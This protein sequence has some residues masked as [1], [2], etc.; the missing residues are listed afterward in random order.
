MIATVNRTNFIPVIF[1]FWC[2]SFILVSQASE[3]LTKSDKNIAAGVLGVQLTVAILTNQVPALTPIFMEALLENNTSNY[4]FV[5][6]VHK[7]IDC[8]V[9]VSDQFG[10]AAPQTQYSTWLAGRK[11]HY[12]SS[13][14][15]VSPGGHCLFT[16]PVNLLYDMS[17]AG[18]YTLKAHVWANIDRDNPSKKTKIEADPL[19]VTVIEVT[20]LI[21]EFRKEMESAHEK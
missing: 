1:V 9:G 17:V 18:E 10:Q 14:K 13:V 7:Y 4:M 2:F 5:G 20:Q 12:G 16:I 15:R 11:G 6:T 8:E 3:P 21:Y 19:K